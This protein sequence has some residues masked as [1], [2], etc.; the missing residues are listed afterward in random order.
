M[1]RP[2]VV[3]GMAAGLLAAAVLHAAA[4]FEAA[5]TFKAS[6]LVP[7]A[8]LKG[9]HHKVEEAVPL[10]G[11]YRQ[12][13]ITSDYGAFDAVGD[14]MLSVRLKEVDALVRLAETSEAEVALKAVGGALG[15]AAKGAAHAV[16]NPGETVAGVPGGV[17]RMFGRVG[18]SAKRTAEKGQEAIK[19]DPSPAPGA[20]PKSTTAA[21]A[22]ATEGAAKSVLGVSAGRRRWAKELG[23]D[24]YTS[25]PV[26]GA[27]LDKVGQIDAAGRFAT[28][29]VPGVG[30]L[31]M[32]S[33]VNALV[34]SKS[35][36][37]LLKHNE[38][39]LKAMGISEAQ[40]RGLRLNKFIRPGAQTKIVASLDALTGVADRAAFL[41]RA[42]A[43]NSEAAALYYANSA[44]MVARLHAAAPLARLVPA[45]A[46]AAALTRDG[47]LVFL[48]PADY[49]AWTAPMAQAAGGAEQRAKAD[50]AGAKGE[51][52]I[53]GDASERTRKE[54]AAKAWKIEAQKLRPEGSFAPAGSKS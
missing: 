11:L 39:R 27:A 42:A 3:P 18:R 24:P 28:K 19:D 50:F 22:D 25:N 2:T 38:E 7:A 48:V 17:G 21:A 15:G 51:V 31:S 33:N 13:R 54:F 9:P 20:S 8:A 53:T 34:Y 12:Y 37:E 40:S 23:V 4:G 36:E 6:D 10:Q 45:Q 16:A 14:G 43:V 35:P 47:R 49:V 44:E 32:V 29:L 26:L 52:W 5:P 1:T 46:A 41:E 30:V